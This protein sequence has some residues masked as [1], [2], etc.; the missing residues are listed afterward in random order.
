MSTLKRKDSATQSAPPWP[1]TPRT[2]GQNA[3]LPFPDN[4]NEI[5]APKVEQIEENEVTFNLKPDI[6]N[7]VFIADTWPALT[8]VKSLVELDPCQAPDEDND[9][10]FEETFTATIAGVRLVSASSSAKSVESVEFLPNTLD[11]ATTPRQRRRPKGSKNRRRD[12]VV[13]P[14]APQEVMMPRK[15]AGAHDNMALR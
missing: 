5:V 4:D 12:P 6:D 8:P 7:A 15:F 11:P 10:S 2:L 3:R 9:D 1:L 13:D 14:D